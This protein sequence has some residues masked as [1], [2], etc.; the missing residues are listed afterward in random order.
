MKRGTPDH[1]KTRHL[2]ALLKLRRWQVVGLLE[3]LWH[4]AAQYARRGDIGK[5]TNAEIAAGIEW[6]GDPDKL[7]ECLSETRW[8]DQSDQYRLLVHDWP[9]HA[10]QTVSRSDEVKKL[11]F[12]SISLAPASNGHSNA[13]QPDP[14][15]QPD[16]A[17][18][19][20]HAYPTLASP[21]ARV[22]DIASPPNPPPVELLLLPSFDTP[23]VREAFAQ[24][25]AYLLANTDKRHFLT[26]PSMTANALTREFRSPG[27]LCKSI[28][29]AIAN[30]WK[31]LK[32]YVPDESRKAERS[33]RKPKEKPVFDDGLP[34]LGKPKT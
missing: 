7:I 5:W 21:E 17:S 26:D 25:F 31:N 34:T 14:A 8:L 15:S 23:E 13:R 33:A 4:F 18:Q 1:P 29:L 20:T 27:E 24:W 2:A 22:G 9:D 3:S 16:H 12:A 28:A 6:E 30:G 19:P 10:D 11:G 32:P